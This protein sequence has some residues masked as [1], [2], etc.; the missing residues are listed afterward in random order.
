MALKM[1][2]SFKNMP[3]YVK[4][5]LS[6]IPALIITLLIIFLILIPKQKEIKNLEQKISAQENEI[7]RDQAKAA[8]LHELTLENEKLRM[9]LNQLK[10]QL[11]EE[12][13]V[14]TLL[15]QVSDLCIGSGLK[16]SL[17]KPEQRKTHTSGIVYEIPVKVDLSGSYHNLGYFFS[18]L[19]R[20]NRI[21]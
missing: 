1:N 5:I 6:V 20:L 8:K 9:R 10:L 17:W 19:T 11:P 16:I 2:V 13:E 21:V 4:L 12:K 18:S 7:A 14:S 3:S 15:K